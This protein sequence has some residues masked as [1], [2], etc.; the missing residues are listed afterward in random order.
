V[1]NLRSEGDV[2]AFGPKRDFLVSTV[3]VKRD[4]Q[5][6]LDQNGDRGAILIG[7]RLRP[8]FSVCMNS[9]L[10]FDVCLVSQS[11]FGW[12]ELTDKPSAAAH[13]VGLGVA[14]V[15][16]FFDIHFPTHLRDREHFLVV[17]LVLKVIWAAHVAVAVGGLVGIGLGAAELM[18]SKTTASY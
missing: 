5:A 11:K 4:T 18:L 1:H 12:N 13:L 7:P 6:A 9:P 17:L 16:R 8:F 3:D 15:E 2:V 10:Q 14:E